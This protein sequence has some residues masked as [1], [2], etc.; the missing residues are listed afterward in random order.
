MAST[1]RLRSFT[2]PVCGHAA[3]VGRRGPLPRA[4]T[5]CRRR[6]VVPAR[7][8][9]RTTC[10]TCGAELPVRGRRG[11]VP[12]RCPRCRRASKNAGRRLY[13]DLT[14]YTAEE[15]GALARRLWQV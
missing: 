7:A 2:C 8:A 14:P 13:V 3:P 12:T 15:L 1:S 6:P 4:C 9:G 11:R 10:S 5:P